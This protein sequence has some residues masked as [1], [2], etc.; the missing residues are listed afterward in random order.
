MPSQA[1][2]DRRGCRGYPVSPSRRTRESRRQQSDSGQLNAPPAAAEVPRR[3]PSSGIAARLTGYSRIIPIDAKCRVAVQPILEVLGY[4]GAGD[5][6]TGRKPS[7]T[8]HRQAPAHAADATIME[9]P[10]PATAR[11]QAVSRPPDPAIPGSATAG[12]ARWTSDRLISIGDIRKL[13]N[14]GRTAAYE[15]THRP[16]FPDP[17]P[18]SSRCYRW[19]ASD[20][21]AFA[22]ALR[23][24]HPDQS[25]RGDGTQRATKPQTPHPATPRRITGKVRAARTRREAP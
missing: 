9:P 21:D 6:G 2:P 18:I 19:W 13:F 15:L 14:L 12:P 20:V 16:D 10:D 25:T 17:V 7:R 4:G 3:I 11:G 5:C 22:D 23:R 1:T 24:K 8:G